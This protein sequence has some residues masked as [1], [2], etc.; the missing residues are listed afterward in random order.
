MINMPQFVRACA[1]EGWGFN[2]FIALKML[3][4]AISQT[5]HLGEKK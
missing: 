2:H 3:G 4:N 5:G 1:S